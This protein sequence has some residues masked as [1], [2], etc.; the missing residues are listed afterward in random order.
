[1]EKY[2]INKYLASFKEE[3]ADL[4]QSLNIEEL[5]KELPSL[6]KEVEDPNLWNDPQKANRIIASYNSKKENVSIYN[7]MSS[8]L[9]DME[10]IVSFI[11]DP[12]YAKLLEE[13]IYNFEKRMKDLEIRITLSGE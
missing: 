9:K 6:S 7:E 13:E 4:Y 8:K 11:D 2:E 5:N 12:E 1:M 3:V 10:E